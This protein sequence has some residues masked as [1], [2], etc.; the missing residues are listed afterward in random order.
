MKNLALKA[1][2]EQVTSCLFQN[3]LFLRNT[4]FITKRTIFRMKVYLSLLLSMPIILF[5]CKLSHCC[6]NNY[7]HHLTSLFRLLDLGDNA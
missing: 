1:F 2:I 4:T 6:N 3:S 5:V 7:F